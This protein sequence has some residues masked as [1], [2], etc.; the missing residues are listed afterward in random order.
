M[1]GKTSKRNFFIG[2]LALLTV[3]SMALFYNLYEPWIPVG[4]ELIPDGGFNTAAATNVWSGWNERTRL[5]ADGGFD[6][7]PGVVLTTSPGQNGILRFTIYNLTNIPAFRVSMRAKAQGVVRGKEGHHVPRA[8]FFFHDTNAKSL[9]SLHHGV[10]DI[11][12]DADWQYYKDF[13]P[14][15]QNAANARLHIQN[16]GAA[17]IMQIDDVSVIPV[18]ERL[19]APWWKMFFGT[20]WT[21]SF[22][23]CLFALRPWARRYGLMI[24]ATL[25]LIMTGIIL[26]GKFL[27]DSIVKSI[28][29]IKDLD[30]KRV[31]P[32]SPVQVEKAVPEQPVRPKPLK[33]K[34]EPILSG[35]GVERTHVMGHFV[36]F[37]LLAF[38]SA[39]SWVPSPPSLKRIVAVCS[40]LIFF[41]AA[42]EVLQFIP[43]GRSAGLSDLQ[44]DIVGMT[45][46]VM[47][48]FILRSFQRLTLRD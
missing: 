1:F 40:G 27:D 42:T 15:P 11:T 4:K 7:S 10:M 2:A 48:V 35:T 16:L 24:T 29:V 21:I 3:G 20:L 44:I 36:L 19:S 37:S 43:A 32:A 31:A 12:R 23:L 47:A 39:L 26:P 14:V 30:E 46:A 41:A 34:D 22:S 5:V 18:R 28:R 9:Y 8:I 25:A 38:L 13:F 45:G 33:P 17:G 6:G